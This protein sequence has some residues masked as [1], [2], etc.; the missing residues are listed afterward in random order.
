MSEL[1]LEKS[2]LAENWILTSLDKIGELTT[3]NTPSKKDDSNYGGFLPWVKPPQLDSELPIMETPEKLSKKGTKKAR[4][5]KKGSVLVSCIGILGKI[6]LAGTDLATNQQINSVTFFDGIEPKYGYYFFKSPFFSNWLEQNKSATVVPI[7][8]KGRFSKA[9]FLLPPLNEQKRIVS[10][11]EKLFSKM[12]SSF[13]ELMK[14]KFQLKSYKIS[15]L[16]FGFI[17]NL[18]KEFR[19][20]NPNESVE[21]LLQAID[22]IKT[23]QEKKLQKIP[24]PNGEYFHEIPNSWKWVRV[25]NICFKLQYGT[26]EKADEDPSGVPVLRM[27]NIIDGELDF[28][29]LK[30]FPKNWAEKTEFL[31]FPDDVLFNRTNSAELVGKTAVFKTHHPESVFASYLIRAK[32]SS[33]IILPFLLSHYVNSVFGR[34]FIKSSISQQVG[35][36]NVNGTKFSMM[37]IPLIPM[38]EQFVLLNKIETGM[39][40]IHSLTKSVETGLNDLQLLQNSILKQA[41]EGKL[42]P[43]DPND[44]P[45]EILLEKIK[46]S[47]FHANTC[48]LHIILLLQLQYPSP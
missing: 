9:P 10:K 7:I 46:Q 48:S 16:K 34:M 20:N 47:Q 26:S 43:Q 36:A 45:A 41:F 6:G 8:N 29:K 19:K 13:N 23:K 5:L 15:L 1:V 44:E 14:I 21:S 30:F 39:S 18:T 11:I 28:N 17:G 3:G 32:V 38:K 12:D 25:G 42:I 24:L 4:V 2:N 31:L 40:L 27:G 35:Q 37:C 22:N 33:S